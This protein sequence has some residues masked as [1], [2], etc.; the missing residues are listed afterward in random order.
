MLGLLT[1][2]AAD[3]QRFGLW[4][5]VLER[6]E[7]VILSHQLTDWVGPSLLAP[8]RSHHDRFIISYGDGSHHLCCLV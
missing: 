5:R 4:F 8:T 1:T 2:T 3:T 6:F 7:N